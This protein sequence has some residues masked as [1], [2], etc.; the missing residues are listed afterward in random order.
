MS[1]WL[2]GALIAFAVGVLIGYANYRISK[3]AVVKNG[4]SLPAVALLRQLFQIGY[5]LILYF[6][7]PYT[8]WSRTPLLVGGA[9]GVTAAILI[10]TVR[11]LKFSRE[12]G[13]V[14][15]KP[16]GEV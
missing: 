4:N 9:L 1:F 12:V 7:A 5:F 14:N 16:G 6:A 13:A 3:A 2:W 15:D 10:F 11:L 8:P